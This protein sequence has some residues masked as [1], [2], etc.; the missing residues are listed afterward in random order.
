[1]D[2]PPVSSLLPHRPPQLYVDRV[3]SVEGGT[4][5]CETDFTPEQFPG[6]FPGRPL[7]PGV[8]MIEG[9]AQTLGCLAAIAGERGQPVLTGVEKARFRG[10]AEPPVRLVF[11]VSI[12]DRRFGV[13]WAKGTVR[14]GDR[15]LCTASLQAT[16]LPVEGA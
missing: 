12:T 7:V 13:T 6:H 1:M 11:E 5:R 4:V 15:V 8:V 16:V 9:L 2:F 14:A 10:M 3:V